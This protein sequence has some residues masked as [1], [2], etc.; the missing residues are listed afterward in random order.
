MRKTVRL[1]FICILTI[2]LLLT[3]GFAQTGG[4]GGAVG[5]KTQKAIAIV[6][7][8]STSMVRDG[9]GQRESDY[10]TRW[11]EADYSVRALAAMMDNGDAL[12]VYP[13][14]EEGYF[15]ATIGRDDLQEN[16]FD[17]L[18]SM[19]YYG[20]TSFDQVRAAADYLK[21]MQ[22]RDCYLV[23]ITDGDFV[24][25]DGEVMTQ[26]ELND[27]IA[28][29]LTPSIKMHYI[30]IGRMSSNRSLPD[31]PAISVHY[32]D[33]KPITRQITD[34]I[35][36][37][38]HRVAMQDEDKSALVTSLSEGNLTVAFNIP[39]QNATIFLQ[40]NMDWAKA[41][42]SA[43]G[44]TS[45]P[46]ELTA[47]SR[48]SLELWKNPRG[49]KREWI[50]A[51]ALSGLV[52]NCDAPDKGSM[53]PVTISGVPGLD[54]EGVQVYY[55]PAVEQQVT[56]MQRDGMSFV[57]GQLDLPLFVEGPVDIIVDYQGLDGK[58]LNL[59]TASMLRTELTTVEVNG[60]LFNAARQE[61]GR[62]VYSGTLSA[63]DAGSSIVISNAIGMEGGKR[64]IPLDA[65]YEPNIALTLG[66][67][68][69]TQELMLDSTG[70]T[71]LPVAI[72]DEMTGSPPK[73][74]P[75]MVVECTSEHFNAAVK[76]FVYEDGVIRIPLSL[77]DVQEHQIDP[78]E[79]FT[80][81]VS[82]PY[83]DSVR[84]PESVEKTLPSVQ[85]TSEPHE[86]SVECEDTS[87]KLN[88]VFVSGRVFPITYLCDG[89]PLTEEQQQNAVLSLTLQDAALNKLITLKDGNI[90]LK[91]WTLQWLNVQNGDYEAELTFSYT[92][93][94]QPAQ[95][96]VPVTLSLSPIT[97]LQ[98]FGFIVSL[99]ALIA[100]MVFVGW[101]VGWCMVWTKTKNGDYIG[102]KT[103]FEL[104][105]LDDPGNFTQLKWLPL[106]KLFFRVKFWGKRY[107]HI[108]RRA[109]DEVDDASLPGCVDLY[110]R[111]EGNCWKLGKIDTRMR[112]KPG[113]FC[114][115]IGGKPVS[116]D[117]CSF[118]A[119]DRNQGGLEI[120][121]FSHNHLW[122]L[123]MM[124]ND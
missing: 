36:E 29:I 53:R 24:N 99:I 121:R 38:Y 77:K 13:L 85:I 114:I 108:R 83:S 35:N 16:L 76:D 89:T 44:Y 95:V 23:V 14:N 106:D 54:M 82:I 87:A 30:Q 105:N 75:D 4:N 92:K 60:H 113:E 15:S 80:V 111:R 33:T 40:G 103:T 71:V 88:H 78:V 49:N 42:Y 118:Q 69:D 59:N 124:E 18:D 48:E 8:D 107:A 117:N 72:N 19:G 123:R 2:S 91:S 31:D 93:W 47:K 50:K 46:T 63:A 10:T 1:L 12:R 104:V 68:Q 27:A 28:E 112:P 96:A 7:D 57:Y 110:I 100:V 3:P 73:W 55:E 52:I 25:K 98:I 94:N 109:T 11:V 20:G 58:T 61:D 43:V 101:F 32:D 34:V 70:R 97:G 39:V 120:K 84:P 5:N 64:F 22:Q 79:R 116:G 66:L 6:L 67:A 90:H 45:K 51:I 122:Y 115:Q 65:V 102:W 62:Y 56:V 86:L 41:E 81:K 9:R 26:K 119:G 17:K 21:G 37:I 74:T